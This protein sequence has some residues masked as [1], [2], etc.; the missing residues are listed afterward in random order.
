MHLVEHCPT[1]SCLSN[2]AHDECKQDRVMAEKKKYR[3]IVPP[4]NK[5]VMHLKAWLYELMKGRKQ[6]T[7]AEKQ[8]HD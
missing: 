4:K 6:D 5:Q 1:I 3:V 2:A 8:S 7:D